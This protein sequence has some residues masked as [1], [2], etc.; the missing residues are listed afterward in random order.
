ME[1]VPTRR[2]AQKFCSNTCRSKAHFHKKKRFESGK[3]KNTTAVIAQ[4]RNKTVP[5]YPSEKTSI[6]KVSIPG[7]ANAA[8][9][10]LAA[11]ALQSM[12]T[13][14]ENKPATKGD[15]KKIISELKGRYYLVQNIP[16]S[17]DGKKPYFD[18]ETNMIV[19]M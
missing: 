19:F 12:F 14:I 3:G 4:E 17:H 9:G 5:K 6:E 7:V 13:K 1:Y 11:N 15:V 2:G 18:M 8:A 16:I 10:T